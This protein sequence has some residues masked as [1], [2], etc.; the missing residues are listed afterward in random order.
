M[1]SRSEILLIL[2]GGLLGVYGG[3]QR[4]IVLFCHCCLST[5]V[6]LLLELLGPIIK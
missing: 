6:V 2:S 3:D 5:M 1:L 4:L